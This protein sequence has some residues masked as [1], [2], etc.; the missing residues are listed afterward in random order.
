MSASTGPASPNAVSAAP[1]QST[2]AWAMPALAPRHGDA[3]R[4][5]SVAATNGTLMA[6]ISRHDT[7]STR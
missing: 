2:G 4:A 5:S 1:S 6:K 3:T 7:A